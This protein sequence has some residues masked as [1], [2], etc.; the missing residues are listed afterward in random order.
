VPFRFKTLPLPE[1]CGILGCF[2]V[3]WA[4]KHRG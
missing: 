4:A 2:L 3:E 1:V